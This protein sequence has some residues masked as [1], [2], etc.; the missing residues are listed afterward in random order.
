MKSLNL[1]KQSK[2]KESWLLTAIQLNKQIS[3]WPVILKFKRMSKRI[4]HRI[5][6]EEKTFNHIQMRIIKIL[7]NKMT[8]IITV[9]MLFQKKILNMNL[10]KKWPIKKKNKFLL[11]ASFQN[12]ILKFKI[13][14]K[15]F[16]HKILIMVWKFITKNQ[17][18]S[19]EFFKITEFPRK[20]LMRLKKVL[21]VNLK[22]S[23]KKKIRK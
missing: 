9:N 23:L 22:M 14:L 3:I 15:L 5:F 19:T 20:I 1:I 11:L 2:I 17:N 10:A 16:L 21:P 12:I 8:K 18:A 13:I 4:S 7:S 6:K